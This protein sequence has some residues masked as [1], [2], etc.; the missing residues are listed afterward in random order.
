MSALDPRSVLASKYE[1][2]FFATNVPTGPAGGDLTGTYPN[3]TLVATGVAPGSYGNAVQ[4]GVFVVDAKGRITN[5]STTAITGVP[6][7]GGAGGD[8]TGTYPNPTL[9]L[10]GVAAGTY[11]SATESSTVTIDAKGRVT[12]A[13]STTLS[14][15]PPGGPAG[16]YLAGTYPNPTFAEAI[17]TLLKTQIGFLTT[18]VDGALAIGPNAQAGGDEAVIVGP[19]SS[20]TGERLTLVGANSL[21]NAALRTVLIG[22]RGYTDS[23]FT[24]IC[25]YNGS[26]NTSASATLVGATT[27]ATNAPLAT[28]VGRSCAAT[29]SGAV[30][31]G[32]N[33]TANQIDGLFVTHRD[34]VTPAAGRVA[35]FN[36]ATKEVSGLP[37]AAGSGYVL[38]GDAIG[39]LAWVA[40]GASGTAGGDL[41]GTFPNPTVAK[42]QTYALAATAPGDGQVMAWDMIAPGWRPQ[43]NPVY[44][45][46]GTQ[47]NSG[48]DTV[49]FGPNSTTLGGTS[50]VAIGN[51]ATAR[52][53]NSVAIGPLATTSTTGTSSVALGSSTNATGVGA[54]AAGFAASATGLSS[55]A[56]GRSTIANAD[57][58][59]AVGNSASC[60]TTGTN[61]TAIGNAANATGG[62]S[63]ALGTSA[64]ATGGSATA[65]GRNTTANAANATSVG[66]SAT[67]S[68]TGTG[69]VAVGSVASATGTNA[70]SIGQ[71][72]VAGVANGVA[73]G[74]AATTN[75]IATS[76]ALGAG[77]S[78]LSTASSLALAVNTAS[79]SPG[80]L[81]ITL[82]GA[83]KVL[84]AYTSLYTTTAGAGPTVLTATSSKVQVFTTSQTVTL[85]V[86]S[87][88]QLGFTFRI[89]NQSAGVVTVQSSGANTVLALGVSTSADFVCVLTSGTTAA[90]WYATTTIP[91]GSAGGD[92]TGSYPNPTLATSGATAGS[93]V[94]AA[95]TID[96]KG[97]FT[98]ITTQRAS[99]NITLSALLGAQATRVLML[100]APGSGSYYVVRFWGL[101]MVYGSAALVTSANYFLMYGAFNAYYA[102]S[103]LADF[104]GL[105]VSSTAWANGPYLSPADNTGLVVPKSGGSDN[106][107]IYF[108]SNAVQTVGTGATFTCKIVYDIVSFG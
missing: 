99:V 6:P 19:D 41:T 103:P 50:S 17:F 9:T 16:G 70:I 69:S 4:V 45:G 56:L 96:A 14:G 68:T 40:G 15:V 74:S 26:I 3:P 55:T 42:L 62:S 30:A 27:S 1:N 91:G 44:Y 59:T 105:T 21:A 98:S 11:G 92:L 89:I 71:N 24:T 93:Y 60:S 94:D 29:A 78:P 13:S 100:A 18:A 7:G 67:C 107:A 47:L 43:G 106:T 57:G 37:Y 73:I 77:A 97:R 35:V 87:T 72:S 28:V 88:L 49:T 38:T 90:S 85:P 2:D 104:S 83:A 20:G 79:V 12:S 32:N 23:D 10:T 65:L 8:L 31:I 64:S 82:N 84:D 54:T 80:T 22:C 81:G 46:T 33:I 61:S 76:V 101:E 86:T 51:A 48:T 95:Y 75:G 102:A 66:A 39:G 53:T 63:V 108:H 25:G 36:T 58:A 52:S 34:D 5:A